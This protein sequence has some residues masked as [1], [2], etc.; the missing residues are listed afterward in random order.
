MQSLWDWKSAVNILFQSWHAIPPKTA[1]DIR[2]YGKLL[3]LRGYDGLMAGMTNALIALNAML[4]AWPMFRGDQGLTGVAGGRLPAALEL[5]WTFKAGQAIK[6][7]AAIVANRVFFGSDDSTLYALSAETG[8]QLWAFKAGQG[9]EASP[10]VLDGTVFVGSVDNNLYALDAAT[11]ALKWKYETGDKIL[12]AANWF[13]AGDSLRILVGSYDF[14]LHCVDA[15][16]GKPVWTCETGN[17]INGMPAVG[18]G[19]VVFGGCDGKLDVLEAGTGKELAAIE[20][21]AYIPGSAAIAGRHAY[22]GHYGDEVLCLDLAGTNIVWR[23]KQTNAPFFSLPAVTEKL[24]IIGARDQQLHGF[25][26]ATG[27]PV[28]SLPT[29][30]DVDG[31]PVVVGDKVVCGSGDGRLYL[32]SLATGTKLWSYDIGKELTASPAVAD[33]LVVIGCEDGVVYAFGPKTSR[34]SP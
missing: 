12:G 8:Q 27:K 3:R 17:Y 4:A 26:R 33:G 21:G 31:S 28:W 23:S 2:G 14:K 7:S 24:V 34:S 1:G 10:L 32:L 9:I 22:V 16:T 11:G 5:R 15:A 20:A 18:N 25:D 19:K 13:R 29:Q 6:S 30:G